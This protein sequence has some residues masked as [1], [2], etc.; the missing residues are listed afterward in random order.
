MVS[1]IAEV[2]VNWNGNFTLLEEMMQ[3]AYDYG[4]DS[5]KLQAFNEDIVKDHPHKKRLLDCSV[6]PE[7]IQKIDSIANNIGVD[8]FAT[9][10]YDDAV[11]LLEP[12]VK[13]FKIRVS[14]GRTLFADKTSSLIEKILETKKET[15]VS[16]E[17]PPPLSFVNNNQIRWL[18]CVS[19]YPC[20]LTDLDFTNLK[21]YDGFSNHC[22]NIAAPLKA[23]ALGAS[24]IEIHVTSDKNI[25]FFDNNVSFDYA[26]QK[27]LLDLIRDYEQISPQ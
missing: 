23:F 13:K 10:M 14:D 9:P 11:L 8:W 18:Y 16:I 20:S 27:M 21:L 2:G 25:D 5:V 17:K 1:I 15:F 26:E 24:V 19:K 4:F 3:H 12:Y 6:S 7:N 22:P